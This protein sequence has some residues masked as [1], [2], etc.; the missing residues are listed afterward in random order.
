MS[1]AKLGLALQLLVLT[2]AAASQP[3]IHHPP[4]PALRF[5]YHLNS[6]LGEPVSFGPGPSGTKMSIPILGGTVEGPNIRGMLGDIDFHALAIQHTDY[7]H[8][9]QAKL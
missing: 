2:G 7:M 1:L 3:A 5:L 9:H 8:H 6:T 4:A